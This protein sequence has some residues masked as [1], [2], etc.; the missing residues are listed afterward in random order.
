MSISKL[1]KTSVFSADER[2]LNNVLNGIG[3][4]NEHYSP[5]VSKCYL[6]QIASKSAI[7]ESIVVLTSSDKTTVE[8]YSYTYHTFVFPAKQIYY[9]PLSNSWL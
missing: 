4:L 2:I 6:F 5:T 3:F 1:L 7:V 8:R 9:I